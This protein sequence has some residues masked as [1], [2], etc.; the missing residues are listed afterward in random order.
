MNSATRLAEVT[1]PKDSMI[2]RGIVADQS[3][4]SSALMG[5]AEQTFLL[6]PLDQYTFQEVFMPRPEVEFNY[7]GLQP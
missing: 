1:I 4:F 6:G 2:F 5:G 3:S 7:G